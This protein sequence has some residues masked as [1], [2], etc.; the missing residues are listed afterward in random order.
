MSAPQAGVLDAEFPIGVAM[1][2]AVAAM[3]GSTNRG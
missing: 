3:T 1:L 2:W